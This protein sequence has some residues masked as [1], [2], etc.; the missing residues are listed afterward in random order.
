MIDPQ[1][2]ER[3]LDFI[4]AT[5]EHYEPEPFHA[6]LCQSLEALE[7]YDIDKL[8]ITAPP[9]SGKTQCASI[10]FPAYWLARNPNDPVLMIS[11][12]ATRA[13]D[14]SSKSLQ[15]MES[16]EFARI[17]PDVKVDPKNKPSDFWHLNRPYRGFMR[18]TGIDGS[19]T[20]LGG[21][22]GIIDDPV[23][24]SQE[25]RSKTM[26]D[27]AWD[28]YNGDF[29]PRLWKRNRQL[30]IMT[31]WIEDDLVGRVMNS[32]E[33][34]DWTVIRLPA[35]C[36]TQEIRDRNNGI[37]HI[38][39][40]EPDPLNREVGESLVPNRLLEADLKKYSLKTVMFSA[41]YQG[42][43]TVAEGD[44]FKRAW[45]E[46][47][48]IKEIPENDGVIHR[49][50]GWDKAATQ[51]GGD[52]TAGVRIAYVPSLKSFFVENCVA[53][54]LSTGNRDT[55]MLRIAEA[56]RNAT[57]NGVKHWHEREPGSS[58]KDSALATDKL[59][60]ERGYPVEHEGASGS[61]IIRAEPYQS[62]WE[63][64]ESGKMF[65]IEGDWNASYI[66]EL[67]GF[68]TAKHDDKVD[69]SSLAFNK[70]LQYVPGM[71]LTAW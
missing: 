21:R 13:D 61:K 30:I 65:I 9:Q 40:G 47:K 67:C 38:Q 43:P 37:Y 51:D 57:N 44:K 1:P 39:S 58:G 15:I 41:E 35:L 46:G 60:K 16:P 22:L 20:G 32:G 24:N 54:Q 66:E 56:D 18:A 48:I 8:I 42:A 63:S 68:P 29:V 25:A 5:Y 62:A 11:Y 23:K 50:R 69:A 45:F 34:K 36:E 55:Y 28:F 70:L 59:F 7:R 17:F 2:K 49:V 19:L 53:L 10:H 4:C 6:Y 31:R 64:E 71:V 33:A 27:Q 3:L 52:F 14:I 26:K 12:G